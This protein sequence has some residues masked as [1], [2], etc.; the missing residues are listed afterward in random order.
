MHSA[1]IRLQ[2]DTVLRGTFPSSQRPVW[3]KVYGGAATC[4]VPFSQYLGKSFF[5]ASSGFSTAS[6]L[7]VAFEVFP[8]WDPYPDAH[9]FDGRYLVSPEFPGLK[10]DITDLFPDYPAVGIVRHTMP[11]VPFKPDGR[12]YRPDGRIVPGVTEPGRGHLFR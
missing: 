1:L 2:I 6:D 12:G 8:W 7:H 9:W 11:A 10:L 5:N 3:L 4:T